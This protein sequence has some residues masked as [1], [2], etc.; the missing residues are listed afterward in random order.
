[1]IIIFC[2][3]ILTGLFQNL[4]AQGDDPMKAWQ[5]FMTSGS[6]HK[7]LAG[8]VGTWEAEVSQWMDST[9]PPTKSKATD[10]VT[11]SMNGLYQV[12]NFSSTMKG[13]PMR[14]QSTLSYDNAKKLFVLAWIDNFESG[15]VYMTGAYDEKTKTLNLKGKQTDPMRGKDTDIRQENKYI[16]DN[17]YTMTMYRA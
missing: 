2:T 1:M 7:W 10:V 6:M 11:M 4:T 9:A 12:G 17:K 8:Q 15:I 5:D 3:V 14:G 16:D 13:M